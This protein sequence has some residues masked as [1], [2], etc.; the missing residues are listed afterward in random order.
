[1]GYLGKEYMESFELFLQPFCK[2][3]IISKQRVER[4]PHTLACGLY[5]KTIKNVQPW[6]GLVLSGEALGCGPVNGSI[7]GRLMAISEA[8]VRIWMTDDGGL[9]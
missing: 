6:E 5:L 4:N 3:E 7:S 1:M 9:Q 2:L 8:L